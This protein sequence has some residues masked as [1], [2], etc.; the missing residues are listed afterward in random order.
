MIYWPFLVHWN[1]V[2]IHELSDFK[3]NDTRI[4]VWKYHTRNFG[5]WF[6][7]RYLGTIAKCAFNDNGLRKYILEANKGK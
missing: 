7:N 1:Q 5:Q 6:K 3:Q 4:A 2:I